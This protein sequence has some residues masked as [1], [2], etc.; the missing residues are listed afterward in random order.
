MVATFSIFCSN[1]HHRN[2]FIEIYSTKNSSSF[3]KK[4]W[5]SVVRQ[6]YPFSCGTAS[7]ATILSLN[8]HL[9]SEETLLSQIDLSQPISFATLA[10]CANKYDLKGKGYRMTWPQFCFLFRDP[11]IV[12]LNQNGEGHFTVCFHVDILRQLVV[13]GDPSCGIRIISAARFAKLWKNPGVNWGYVLFFEKQ[14]K[15]LSVVNELSKM[16]IPN[17]GRHLDRNSPLGIMRGLR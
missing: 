15:N 10:E 1:S 17:C 6:K 12:A 4:R 11:C 5:R 16:I 9:I 3:V 7:L 13:L 14:K 2:R 8:G